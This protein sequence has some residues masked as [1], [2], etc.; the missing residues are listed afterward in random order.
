MQNKLF[1]LILILLLNINNK[2]GVKYN[3]YSFSLL[4]NASTRRNASL[5]YVQSNQALMPFYMKGFRHD[6]KTAFK[7]MIIINI[8]NLF[9]Y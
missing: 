4:N 1:F 8:S 6:E 9:K 2:N 3:I 5:F 7:R